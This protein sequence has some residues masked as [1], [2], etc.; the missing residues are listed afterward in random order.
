[1]LLSEYGGSALVEKKF[2]GCVQSHSHHEHTLMKLSYK[3]DEKA[4]EWVRDPDA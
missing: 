2:A 1:M 3:F 4:M